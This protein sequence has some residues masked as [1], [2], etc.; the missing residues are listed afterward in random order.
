MLI[1]AKFRKSEKS[2]ITQSKKEKQR[3]VEFSHVNE[4][5]LFIIYLLNFIW[6]RR[7]H[8]SKQQISK[9]TSLPAKNASSYTSSQCKCKMI[10]KKLQ[11]QF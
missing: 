5:A 4:K 7:V 10:R 6:D 11:T 8:Q 2:L 3:V 9:R 1:R